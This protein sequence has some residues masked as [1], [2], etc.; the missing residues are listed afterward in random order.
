LFVF[1]KVQSIIL[2]TP[3]PTAYHDLFFPVQKEGVLSSV[4]LREGLSPQLLDESKQI[5]QSLEHFIRHSRQIMTRT[6][7]VHVLRHSAVMG[8]RIALLDR[9]T[10]RYL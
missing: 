5:T 8:R 6:L 7:Y 2:F 4:L 3:P 10:P 1:K 9:C